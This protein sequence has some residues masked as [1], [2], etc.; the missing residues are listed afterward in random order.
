MANQWTALNTFWNSFDIPAYDENTVPDDATMPYITYEASI[1]GLGDILLL[2]A[3][4]WYGATM[5]WAGISEKA[6]EISEEIG[7]GKSV[8]YDNGRLWATKMSPFAQ[9]MADAEGVRRVLMHIY[10]EYQT[11]E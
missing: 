6:L 11:A 4:L 5:S 7:G 8:G 2:S 9:R 1:G 3:S 10:A